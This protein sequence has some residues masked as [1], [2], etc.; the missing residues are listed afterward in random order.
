MCQKAFG[1]YFAP[2]GGVPLKDLVNTLAGSGVLPASQQG[3]LKRLQ[4]MLNVVGGSNSGAIETRQFK[5]CP[6]ASEPNNAHDR[7]NDFSSR[8]GALDCR[9]EDR[10]TE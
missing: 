6:G 4:E 7:S 5:R 8:Q 1:N 3:Q 2:L 9:E 10:A